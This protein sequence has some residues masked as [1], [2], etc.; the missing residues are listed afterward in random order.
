MQF[1]K[2]LKQIIIL[3]IIVAVFFSC[4][5]NKD[6][7]KQKKNGKPNV[8]L[9]FIDDMGYGDLGCYGATGFE[10]PN[11]DQM[12]ANG[13]TFTNFYAAQPVCS[14]SRAGL[15]TGCYPNRIGFSGALFPHHN[16][17]LNS[18]EWTIA[19]M[20]KEQ[21]Y[22]TACFGK[23]H[24]GWQEEF[25]PLQH[26]FDEYVGLPYSNDMWPHS[27]I[28]GHELPEDK[29]R[30]KMPP[31]PLI[32][33]NMVIDT[34]SSMK[35][36]D[37]LTTLYTEKAVDFINRNAEKPFF[38]YLP[39]TMGHIP[40]GVSDK[41][42]GKS[43]QGFYG[44][45][46]MEID[47]SVGEINKALEK[48]GITDNTIVIFTTDNGPWLNFGNH[49]GSSG[50]LREG[51][52]TSWEGGQ[53]V[54]F[55]I[56]WPNNIPEGVVCNHLACAIDLLPTLASITE[57]KL[58]DNKIDGVDITSLFKGDFNTNPR[59]TI[60]YYFGKNNLNGLRKGNWKLVL[61]HSWKSYNAKPG[62]DGHAGKRIKM[63]IETP[64]LY[65][66]MRDPGE[67][68]NVYEHY[69]EKVEELMLEVEKARK[70]LGDINVGIKTGNGNRKI[71]RLK[72]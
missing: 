30:G 1:A 63:T 16:V 66:M 8:V 72:Q 64:E 50:G 34:I 47:W 37:K 46:M 7:N 36:Q 49:A 53:R 57:G 2:R 15:L 31:L 67:Q 32:E 38:V 44:D 9:I 4:S 14:A 33:G 17:G 54:P 12:A 69:P 43:E 28:D 5:S 29:G 45:V 61:P 55:I 59:K 68:Y 23:W 51:K 60:W 70:E 22:A 10:T 25:L 62:N 65:N 40:L 42:R 52:T 21:D 6:S 58:S 11:L 26:G 19:E 20:F 35:D 71:G 24:L 13:M 3:V 39:H 41:F 27:N 18:D 56:N 48:N